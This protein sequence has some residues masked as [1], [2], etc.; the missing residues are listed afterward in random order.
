[1][2][3]LVGFPPELVY[4]PSSPLVCNCQCLTQL[5]TRPCLL[6]SAWLLDPRL[7]EVKL[8]NLSWSYTNMPPEYCCL[9]FV[10]ALALQVCHVVC[11]FISTVLILFL[12][13]CPTHSL[14][15]LLPALPCPRLPVCTRGFNLSLWRAR[16][17]HHLC[18]SL[19][20]SQCFCSTK[21]F[22]HS[23]KTSGCQECAREEGG[24]CEWSAE[25][26]GAGLCARC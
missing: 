26:R 20:G 22:L 5:V 3:K 17:H 7:L 24:A 1:M 4:P 9:F 21:S 23:L 15:G 19:P 14:T 6:P 12:P 25:T 2:Y 11:I 10:W 18:L 8:K 13:S 16:Q